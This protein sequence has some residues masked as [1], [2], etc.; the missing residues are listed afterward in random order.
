MNK[1]YDFLTSDKEPF[2]YFDKSMIRI[3]DGFLIAFN[4]KNGKMI[5]SPSSHMVLYIEDLNGYIGF[6]MIPIGKKPTNSFFD[7]ETNLDEFFQ[8]VKK[9]ILTNKKP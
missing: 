1:P 4:G 3:D 5:I 7:I 2:I 9:I 6:K 8:P